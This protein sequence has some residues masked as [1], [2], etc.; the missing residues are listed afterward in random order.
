MFAYCQSNRFRVR[1]VQAQMTLKRSR[2]RRL[3]SAKSAARMVQFRVFDGFHEIHSAS[4][5]EKKNQMFVAESSSPQAKDL[6]KT[7][8]EIATLLGEEKVRGA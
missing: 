1:G 5:C 2:F 4:F 8:K 6:K 3:V 7:E